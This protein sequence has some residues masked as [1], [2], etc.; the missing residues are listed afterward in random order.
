MTLRG[1]INMPDGKA[2]SFV[3]ILLK[4]DSST[5]ASFALEHWLYTA[6]RL[7]LLGNIIYVQTRKSSIRFRGN[8]DTQVNWRR[9]LSCDFSLHHHISPRLRPLRLYNL[10]IMCIPIPPFTSCLSLVMPIRT[11]SKQESSNLTK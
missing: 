7:R 11:A 10:V 5:A 6:D 9:M 8:F 2:Q 3:R 4:I 1:A